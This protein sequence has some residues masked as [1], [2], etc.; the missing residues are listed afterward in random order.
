MPETIDNTSDE[1][2]CDI[3]ELSDEKK[4]RTWVPIFT[5][6]AWVIAHG[7]VEGVEY[8]KCHFGYQVVWVRGDQVGWES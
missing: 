2:L 4:Y 8:K 5:N 1:L 3:V 7:K 6:E